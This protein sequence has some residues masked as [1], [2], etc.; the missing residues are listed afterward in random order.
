MQ[1]R[2]NVHAERAKRNKSGQGNLNDLLL[3]LCPDR[4]Q[5][6]LKPIIGPAIERFVIAVRDLHDNHS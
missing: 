5:A 6:I 3:K 2:N 4:S 1:V